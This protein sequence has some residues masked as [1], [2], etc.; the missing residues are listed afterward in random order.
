MDQ[1]QTNQTAN[2]QPKPNKLQQTPTQ[3]KQQ[4]TQNT[5]IIYASFLSRFLA[6][7]IDFF[8]IF[9]LIFF[10]VTVLIFIIAFANSTLEGNKILKVIN[11]ILFLLIVGIIFGIYFFYS[12]IFLTFK[13]TT[14]GKRIFN[15]VVVKENNKKITFFTALLRELLGKIVSG[16]FF[17]IGYYWVIWDEK[18]QTWHDK[19]AGTIVIKKSLQ[20]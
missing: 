20:K 18:K 12:I 10:T 9:F 5:N 15:L 17:G 3:P 8:I 16:L 1:P 6:Y 14:P 2:Q 11:T 4:P 19:I 7:T 13:G